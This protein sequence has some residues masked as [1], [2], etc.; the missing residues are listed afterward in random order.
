M[1]YDQIE[2]A[3][4]YVKSILGEFKPELAIL[5]G[6]GMQGIDGIG[7]VLKEIPYTDIPHFPEAT[8]PSHAGVLKMIQV[9]D[10]RILLFSGR[11]HY[12]E[13]YE[14]AQVCFPIY[15]MKSLGV[16]ELIMTNA[17][18]GLNE[19]YTAGDI[20]LVKDHM[21]F[22][23]SNPLVGKNDDR[24]GLRFPDMS[25]AYSKEMRKTFHTYMGA[26][27]KEGVY[28]SMLGPSL[29]TPAEYKFLHTVG[30]DMV[31]M[32]TV[33]EVIACAHVGISVAVLS[34]VSNMCYPVVESSET[35]IESVIKIVHASNPKVVELISLYCNR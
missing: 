17:S 24:L 15:L 18:G 8:V 35:T 26:G 32:S 21:N 12:Y 34:I 4:V 27:Y 13:G 3:S 25:N 14:G 11:F 6:T 29:E 1:N 23:G 31:G 2:K 5:T 22:M 30:A 16:K 19:S 20:V 7:D 10:R 9:K 28:A 33:P